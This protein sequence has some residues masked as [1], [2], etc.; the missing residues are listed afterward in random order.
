MSITHFSEEYYQAEKDFEECI[1]RL[2]ALLDEEG[3]EILSK[4]ANAHRIIVSEQMG[5]RFYEGW[6]HGVHFM[7]DYKKDI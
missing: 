5:Q 3:R 4:L 7:K 2:N 1:D 6:Y